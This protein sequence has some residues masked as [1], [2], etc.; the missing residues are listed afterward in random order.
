MAVGWPFDVLYSVAVVVAV[1]SS[2]ASVVV[3]AEAVAHLQQF[4][5]A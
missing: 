3:G 5:G 1:C 4:A 2:C